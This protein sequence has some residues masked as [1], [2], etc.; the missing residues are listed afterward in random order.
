MTK[1]ALSL[2]LFAVLAA[3]NAV[4]A[5]DC[6]KYLKVSLLVTRDA[7]DNHTASKP[8]PLEVLLP[9]DAPVE[10]ARS[11]YVAKAGA[12]LNAPFKPTEQ[13]K[14]LLAVVASD[15][16]ALYNPELLAKYSAMAQRLIEE[17]FAPPGTVKVSVHKLGGGVQVY[18]PMLVRDLLKFQDWYFNVLAPQL[19]ADLSVTTQGT[20]TE[21][22]LPFL[23]YGTVI[24]TGQKPNY[25]IAFDPA[26]T[27]I[28]SN[29]QN[30]A[31]DTT[32]FQ[33]RTGMFDLPAM[34]KA[35]ISLVRIMSVEETCESSISARVR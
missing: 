26:D 34:K 12:F 15:P 2:C 30:E 5:D 7:K 3:S 8:D 21:P 29:P 24:R 11:L 4:L 20:T 19:N 18:H 10:A 1:F 28:T 33:L 32:L 6:P 13:D 14:E 9:L 17:A 31:F 35:D 16:R 25:H 23:L 27:I 22:V